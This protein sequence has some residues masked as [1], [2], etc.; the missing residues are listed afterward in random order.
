MKVPR[1]RMRD[2]ARALGLS[3]A[4]VSYCLSGKASSQS[5]PIQTQRRV[6]QYA[7]KTAYVPNI[8]AQILNTRAGGIMD[9]ALLWDPRGFLDEDLYAVTRRI[10]RQGWS[11]HVELQD[12]EHPGGKSLLSQICTMISMGIP[13]VLVLG[14]GAVDADFVAAVSPY[15]PRVEIYVVNHGWKGTRAQEQWPLL[16]S[17]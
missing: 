12:G 2:I 1:P 7:D 14:G 5:I 6:M 8:M 10:A 17:P 13:R 3:R 15:L 9:V 11:Y 16:H 4:T